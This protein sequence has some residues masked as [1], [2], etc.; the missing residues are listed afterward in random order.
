[1]VRG[2]KES[3]WDEWAA[4]CNMAAWGDVIC[5][6]NAA[7]CTR[8]PGWS[9]ALI[10]GSVRRIF[11]HRRP[12][13][14][15]TETKKEKSTLQACWNPHTVLLD[16]LW[17]QDP[18]KKHLCEQIHAS[19]SDHLPLNTGCERKS[20]LNAP[21]QPQIRHL[22]KAL[23]FI[24]LFLYFW[25]RLPGK[26]KNNIFFSVCSG[27]SRMSKF[28]SYYLPA[29]TYYLKTDFISWNCLISKFQLSFKSDLSH[30][31]IRFLDIISNFWT[32]LKG[33]LLS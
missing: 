31:I 10:I 13:A 21:V 16:C 8:P 27:S 14:R 25:V 33:D 12:R 32:Y 3:H 19:K 18:Q 9:S 11:C 1:M 15:H 28:W 20:A 7:L 29:L 6:F 30:Y 4:G 5:Q 22:L 23:P 17:N 2:H 24:Y 26:K